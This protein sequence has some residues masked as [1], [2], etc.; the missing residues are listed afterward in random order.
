MQGRIV[1]AL[2][3]F[4]YV[5]CENA[6]YECRARGSFRREGIS[7]VVGDIVNITAT[8]GSHGVVE[9]VLARKNILTRPAVANIDKL[10]IVS[11]YS[12]PSPDALM[13]DRLTAI[14]IYHNIEPIVV[15]N[16]S[17]MGDFSEWENVYLKSGFKTHTVS[18]Q[19]GYGIRE[20]GEELS[21][22]VCAFAGNS[23]VGKSSILNA[24]FGEVKIKTGEVSEKL[25]RGRH[26]TRHIEL[27]ENGMGGFIVDTPGFSSVEESDDYNFKERLAE[28]FPDFEKGAQNCRFTGCT[29]T[30]EKGCGV[31]QGLNDGEIQPSRHKSYCTIFNELK[32]LKPWSSA[33]NRSQSATKSR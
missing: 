1:K 27:Y 13:I 24:L 2:S 14:A 3:G 7:P 10:V 17:D 12:V 26:T 33:G 29:H 22:C 5:N 25:G 4:Y 23:G 28:C 31:L 15:F 18:A 9:E 19:S 30:C 6:I 8:D 21:G 11:S 16:K 20:L 32:D